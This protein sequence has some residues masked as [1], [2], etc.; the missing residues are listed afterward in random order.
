MTNNMTMIRLNVAEAKAR[1]SEY[2]DRL[3]R[4]EE[5]VVVICRRNQPIAELR[6]MPRPGRGRRPI[7]RKD[8][9]FALAPSF[10][11]PLPED[12][13]AAFEGKA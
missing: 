6:A 5:D 8:P 2:L 10:F 13:L 1:L 3:E 9:R 4:G 11:A 7:L 12:V